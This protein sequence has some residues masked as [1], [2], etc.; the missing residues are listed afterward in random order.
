MPACAPSRL[1]RI[2]D[3][4]LWVR[5]R[6]AWKRPLIAVISVAPIGARGSSAALQNKE[7]QNLSGN[8]ILNELIATSCSYNRILIER[9]QGK[10]SFHESDAMIN[11]IVHR[12]LQV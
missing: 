1:M 11:L 9:N 4:R 5:Q 8:G 3:K 10:I 7:E 12:L 6:H 2:G